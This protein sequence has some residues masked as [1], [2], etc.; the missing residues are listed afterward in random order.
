M[1]VSDRPA[2]GVED[3]R[4]Q[5]VFRQCGLMTN[6]GAVAD[7][8]MIGV[9]IPAY[10]GVEDFRENRPAFLDNDPGHERR[11]AWRHGGLLWFPIVCPLC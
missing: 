11:G 5:P 10:D 3:E 9:L 6:D 1:Q 7:A 8:T 2:D 4:L